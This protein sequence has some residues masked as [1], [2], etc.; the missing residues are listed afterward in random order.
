MSGWFVAECEIQL[1]ESCGCQHNRSG[2][3]NFR[4]FLWVLRIESLAEGEG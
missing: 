3:Y 2:V 1:A 4:L